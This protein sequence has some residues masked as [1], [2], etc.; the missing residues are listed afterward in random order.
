[1]CAVPFLL[2]LLV[3]CFPQVLKSQLARSLW[4]DLIGEDLCSRLLGKEVIHLLKAD[5]SVCDS[6]GR[7]M[8]TICF[9]CEHG[10]STQEHIHTFV[11]A[12]TH[13]YTHTHLRT[14]TS[15]ANAYTP[16]NMYNHTHPPALFAYPS[17]CFRLS[18]FG[19]RHLTIKCVL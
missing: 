11:Y 15:H 3:V 10:S 16:R 2:G 7:L 1:M 9:F 17:S 13:I 19:G 4:Q 6:I 8:H 12:C 5:S 18:F 14:C